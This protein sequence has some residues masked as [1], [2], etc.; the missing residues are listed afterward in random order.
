[1]HHAPVVQLPYGE[2]VLEVGAMLYG[3]GEAV[4]LQV[5][6]GR[7]A[8]CDAVQPGRAADRASALQSRRGARRSARRGSQV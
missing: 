5:E 7:A 2:K 8:Q 3:A 6:T 4:D 1:V